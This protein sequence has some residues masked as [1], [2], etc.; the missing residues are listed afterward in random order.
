MSALQAGKLNDAAR[1]CK[2][3]LRAE[4][5]HVEAH[6]LLGHLLGRL[7]RNAQ[8]VASFDR[9]LAVD[10]DSIEAWYGHGM[11]LVAMNRPQQAIKSFERVVACCTPRRGIVGR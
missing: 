4:P 2:A 7:G 1:L 6:N 5:Q 9:A 11:T 3:V 8:A 10:P